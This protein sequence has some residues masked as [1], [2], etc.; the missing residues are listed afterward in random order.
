MIGI[1]AANRSAATVPLLELV[2]H[3]FRLLPLD[4]QL[5]VSAGNVGLL[6]E[7]VNPKTGGG[8]GFRPSPPLI[9][10]RRFTRR[11]CVMTW[12]SV[13][14]FFARPVGLSLPS[15]FWFGAIGRPSP[16]PTASSRDGAIP[17]PIRYLTTASAR[18]CESRWL[19]ASEP[20]E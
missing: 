3:T 4:N 7:S 2:E 14:R 13:R 9:S 18:R 11:Y 12:N 15:G 8:D 17:L 5:G 10:A 16:N 19:Y 1:S 20:L 6:E